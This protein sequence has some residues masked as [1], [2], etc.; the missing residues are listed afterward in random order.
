MGTVIFS[1]TGVLLGS[2]VS[3]VPI[4]GCHRADIRLRAR[5]VGAGKEIVDHRRTIPT[6]RSEQR[7]QCSDSQAC[8][9]GAYQR[10]RTLP[11]P[12]VRP[13][14]HLL[15]TPTTQRGSA[16]YIKPAG[17]PAGTSG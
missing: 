10:R 2:E 11:A 7:D 17:M 5:R 16:T 4:G 1:P 15:A 6:F 14:A 12:Q 3:A 13:K 9:Q 8:V